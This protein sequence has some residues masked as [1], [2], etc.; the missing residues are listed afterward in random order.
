MGILALGPFGISKNNTARMSIYKRPGSPHF[1]CRFEIGGKEIRRSTG[2]T[3]RLQAAEF[4]NHIRQDAW[5]TY[6]LRIPRRYFEEG[7]SRWLDEH[8]DKRSAHSDRTIIKWFRQHLDG[9]LLTDIDGDVIAQLRQAKRKDTLKNG[10]PVSRLT[11]NRHMAWLRSMLRAAKDQWEW[12]DAHPKIPMY[13]EIPLEPRWITGKQFK[14]LHTALPPYLARCAAFAV[15]TGLR[16]G[17][18]RAVQWNQ[19]N[20]RKRVVLVKVS[21]AKNAKALRVPL[22]PNAMEVLRE[23][24]GRG[25]FVFTK[26]GE[27]VPVEMVNRAWRRACKKAKLEGL[28][29]HDLRHTWASWHVQKGTPLHVLQQLGGWSSI[30]MVQRYAHLAPADLDR[31]ARSIG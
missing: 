21:Q 29:F 5:H 16:A 14:N 22:G 28:R 1:Y 23:C 3:D 7:A 24:K 12:I 31:W 25:D 4:E 9:M 18:I 27:Q 11:V 17:P 30:E 8:D 19:V 6:K 20:M 2:T 13:R 10:K 26:D 15:Y